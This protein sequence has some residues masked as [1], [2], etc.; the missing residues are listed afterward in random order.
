MYVVAGFS[1]SGVRRGFTLGDAV[2]EMIATGAPP[3]WWR[4]LGWYYDQYSK[5]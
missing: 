3:R 1:G 5:V 4:E 2:A